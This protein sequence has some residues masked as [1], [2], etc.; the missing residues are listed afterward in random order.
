MQPERRS[1]FG[2]WPSARCREGASCW[3]STS[4]HESTKLCQSASTHFKLP[5]ARCAGCGC[6]CAAFIR[7]GP[8]LNVPCGV[9][10]PPAGDAGSYHLL[11]YHYQ[12]P[13]VGFPA[14]PRSLAC[15]PALNSRPTGRSRSPWRRR[16]GA[17]AE[18][19]SQIL[20]LFAVM[21]APD[22]TGPTCPAHWRTA[23]DGVPAGR[24]PG[25]RII[26]YNRHWLLFATSIDPTNQA[27]RPPPPIFAFLEASSPDAVAKWL[28]GEWPC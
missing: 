27:N 18:E 22:G 8:G 13:Q 28:A 21:R 11:S 3:A 5:A 25:I 14:F 2:L 23:Q 15:L 9:L 6:S 16:P 26:L 12:N 17:T 4:S 7:Y 19:G 1:A 24:V 10:V 20:A